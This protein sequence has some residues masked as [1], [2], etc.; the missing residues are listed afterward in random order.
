MDTMK[1]VGFHI[2]LYH[3]INFFKHQ[4]QLKLQ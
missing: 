1:Q 2:T 4:I 3:Y